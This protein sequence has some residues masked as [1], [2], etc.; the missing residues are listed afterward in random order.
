[1]SAPLPTFTNLSQ[2]SGLIKNKDHE[3]FQEEAIGELGSLISDR[4]FYLSALGISWSLII[5]GMWGLLA[6]SLVIA[7]YI[8]LGFSESI[9]ISYFAL[10]ISD[11]GVLVTTMWGAICITLEFMEVDLPFRAMEISSPTSYWPGEGFEKTTSCITAYIAL[12][13]CLCILFPLHVKTIVTRGKTSIVVVTIFVLVYCPS[14]LCFIF[15]IFHWDF[16]PARNRSVLSNSWSVSGNTV[17]L[18]LEVY[19]GY[20]VHFTSLLVMWTSSV[21]LAIALRRTIQ[22]SKT[23]LGL[24]SGNVGFV[25]N[26]RVM[27]TVLSIAAA[28][29]VFST[30]RVISNAISQAFGEFTGLGQYSK[31]YTISIFAG[32]QLSLFNSSVNLVIYMTISSK[33]REIVWEILGFQFTKKK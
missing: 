32:V 29:L 15:R 30:P 27:K 23:S 22:S 24:N 19:Y 9:N 31:L 11:T 26:K 14:N 1:M 25:R 7:T 10:G 20:V 2:G 18:V 3:P 8:K 12:E 28:Y 5:T 16:D 33:F 13:R 6:N 17:Y 21:F 4:G